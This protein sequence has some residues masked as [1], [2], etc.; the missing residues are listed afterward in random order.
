MGKGASV[1]IPCRMDDV[2]GKNPCPG[3]VSAG[4]LTYITYGTF[5]HLKSGWYVPYGHSAAFF[6]NE[7]LGILG[8]TVGVRNL[9]YK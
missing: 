7:M 8:K 1:F 2:K 5:V 9:T 3:T 6:G 4:H